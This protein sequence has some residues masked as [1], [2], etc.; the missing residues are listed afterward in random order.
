M[1]CPTK[2]IIYYIQEKYLSKY[3][4]LEGVKFLSKLLHKDSP[5]QQALILLEGQLHNLK[6]QELIGILENHLPVRQANYRVNEFLQHLKESERQY[7][8]VYKSSGI[9]NK[10]EGV[11]EGNNPHEYPFSSSRKNRKVN[12]FLPILRKNGV[13]IVILVA[14]MIAIFILMPE[15]KL[16]PLD[17]VTSWNNKDAELWAVH[18][19]S[20]KSFRE[21]QGEKNR[22]TNRP[23]SI[24]KLN[25]DRFYLFIFCNSE[26]AALEQHSKQVKEEWKYSRIIPID[27]CKPSSEIDREYLTC[28]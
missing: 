3:E 26:E 14:V 1:W 8:F 4:A 17:Q 7:T 9:H 18:L 10:I 5:H 20:F 15:K 23:I 25:D 11:L 24:I 6:Q 28:Q 27:L 16:S 22:F 12:K 13:N 2:K 19:R 21:A